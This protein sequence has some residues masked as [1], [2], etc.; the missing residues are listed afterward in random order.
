MNYFAWLPMKITQSSINTYKQTGLK[1]CLERNC[2]RTFAI[3]EIDSKVASGF[4]LCHIKPTQYVTCQKWRKIR[5]RFLPAI[6]AIIIMSI[7]RSTVEA[8]PQ[9]SCKAVNCLSFLDEVVFFMRNRLAKVEVS[10]RFVCCAWSVSTGRIPS[11]CKTLQNVDHSVKL[12]RTSMK[13][14]RL[15]MLKRLPVTIN[16][17]DVDCIFSY[18]EM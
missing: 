9:G 5:S 10:L 11:T 1:R 3:L 15:H 8:T 2:L 4:F 12:T 6:A 14:K 17:N 16:L 13:V 18:F 7:K